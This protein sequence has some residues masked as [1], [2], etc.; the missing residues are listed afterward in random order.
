MTKKAQELL[1][2]CQRLAKEDGCKPLEIL[3]QI[4]ED[5]G[6][7]VYKEVEDFLLK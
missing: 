5:W 3:H 4:D 7:D 1:A 2:L 6:Y